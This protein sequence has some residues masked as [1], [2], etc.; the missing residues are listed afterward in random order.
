MANLTGRHIRININCS[1][2]FHIHSSNIFYVTS[3]A[4]SVVHDWWMLFN[5]PHYFLPVQ[6][7][8]IPDH[9][10]NSFPP[11]V[12]I[13]IGFFYM[14]TIQEFLIRMQLM[15]NNYETFKS[16]LITAPFTGSCSEQIHISI[17]R[18]Y[19]IEFTEAIKP[20]NMWYVEILGCSKK[21]QY[22]IH[23]KISCNKSRNTEISP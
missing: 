3:Q 7:T 4:K 16:V 10:F 18:K 12:I 21:S 23:N 19:H 5:F 13:L 11:L 1:F 9:I 15:G 6:S 2:S 20:L 22:N 8:I 17:M 14:I